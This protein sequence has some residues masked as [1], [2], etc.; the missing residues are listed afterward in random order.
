MLASFCKAHTHMDWIHTGVLVGIVLVGFSI[1]VS[2][3]TVRKLANEP[4][5]HF[6]IGPITVETLAQYCGYDFTKPILVAIKGKVYDVTKAAEDFGPGKEVALTPI[7]LK[8]NQK[9][10]I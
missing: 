9:H 6:Q 3:G 2:L 1:Y 10:S 7:A 4:H 8:K 5:T